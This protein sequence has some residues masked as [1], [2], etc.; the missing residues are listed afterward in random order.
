MRRN[1]GSGLFPNNLT[2]LQATRALKGKVEPSGGRKNNLPWFY[3]DA[4]L[5][6]A[7][8]SKL[9]RAFE[10]RQGH[11]HEAAA[12]TNA[13][14]VAILT[15]RAGVKPS[16]PSPEPLGTVTIRRRAKVEGPRAGA[17]RVKI[18]FP[19]KGKKK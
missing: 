18:Y 3:S 10:A 6:E 11:L 4:R 13:E 19:R 5:S 9:I 14:Y 1:Q 17:R 16:A 8:R 2:A 7:K 12:R 15:A